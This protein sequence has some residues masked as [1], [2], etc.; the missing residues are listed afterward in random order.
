MTKP[1]DQERDLG[2][3]VAK[4]IIGAAPISI[5]PLARLISTTLR[6]GIEAATPE[7][8]RIPLSRHPRSNRTSA[9][10]RNPT[11]NSLRQEILSI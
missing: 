7:A 4:P 6:R 2:R 8:A 3:W 11:K 1:I 10:C 5:R 9:S